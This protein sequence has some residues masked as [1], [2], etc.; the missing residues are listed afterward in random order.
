MPKGSQNIYEYDKE[1]EF[2]AFRGVSSFLPYPVNYGM[3]PQT[4]GGDDNPLDVLV[5][6]D[7]PTFSGCVI[8]CRPIAVMRMGDGKG[9]DDKILSVPLSNPQFK[10]MKDLKDIPQ[11]F[12][13]EITHFFQEF[14]KLGGKTAHVIDW[15]NDNNAL[16]TIERGKDLYKQMLTIKSLFLL[17]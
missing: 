8:E 9:R 13:D 6:M 3:I 16:R 12:L 11:S 14:G 5:I 4:M 2:F 1:K 7:Q 15:E 10:E 17:D